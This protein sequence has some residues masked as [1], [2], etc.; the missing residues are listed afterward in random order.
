LLR[1]EA[2][3]G[4]AESVQAKSV[5]PTFIWL[6]IQRTPEHIVQIGFVLDAAVEV[7]KLSD[8]PVVIKTLLQAVE[9]GEL[10]AAVNT[11][12]RLRG[13]KSNRAVTAKA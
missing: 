12:M 9:A 13:A 11:A 8:L 7:A 4:A 3:W 6:V 2:A 5:V 10:D 1:H